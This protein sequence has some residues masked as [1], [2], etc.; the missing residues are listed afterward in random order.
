MKKNTQAFLTEV[1]TWSDADLMQGIETATNCLGESKTMRKIAV[2]HLTLGLL[3]SEVTARRV[4]EMSE[5]D[6]A[7][8]GASRVSP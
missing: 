7:R 5:E 2:S 3:L 6:W 4:V 8:S 1:R